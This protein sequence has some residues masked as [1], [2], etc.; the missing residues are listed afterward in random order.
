MYSILLFFHLSWTPWPSRQGNGSWTQED[1]QK[2][3]QGHP[4]QTYTFVLVQ[5]H[6][7]LPARSLQPVAA[8][9]SKRWVPACP[10]EDVD[11]L[12]Q[13]FLRLPGKNPLEGILLGLLELELTVQATGRR[14]EVLC[15]AFM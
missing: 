15:A 14:G 10:R 1:G 2:S 6:D 7:D 11:E 5:H 13:D 12:K 3:A 9:G 8:L 4:T